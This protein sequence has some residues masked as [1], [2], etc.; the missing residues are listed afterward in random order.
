[1]DI[2]TEFLSL[3]SSGMSER[4][5]KFFT[6]CCNQLLRRDQFS[7][8]CRDVHTMIISGLNGSLIERCP[9][10]LYGCDELQCRFTPDGNRLIYNEYLESFAV[11]S[12]SE[13]LMVK[14]DLSLIEVLPYELLHKVVEFLDTGSLYCLSATSKHLRT[15]CS[16]FLPSHGVTDITWVK[17]KSSEG[18][19]RW[20]PGKQVKFRLC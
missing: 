3:G 12:T 6:F 20:L 7:D 13:E 19:V 4:K 2:T 18:L 10:H 9:M 15:L 17:T 8:H 16:T 1:M 14:N 11:V 5:K